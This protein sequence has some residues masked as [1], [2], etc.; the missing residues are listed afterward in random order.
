MCKRAPCIGTPVDIINIIEAK[1]EDFV[2]KNFS[3][4]LLFPLYILGVTNGPTRAIVQNVKDDGSCIFFNNDGLCDI[5]EIKPTEGLW[6]NC[7]KGPN[8][9]EL[10][11]SILVIHEW[12]VDIDNSLRLFNMFM[13]KEEAV[14]CVHKNR[15]LSF[16]FDRLHF[17]S[18]K[19][20][21]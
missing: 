5:H 8:V 3:P 6:T 10:D 1:G 13:P 17:C 18:L 21:S 11:P 4:T 9:L 14:S 7:H 19:K 16:K 15:S 20:E 12:T 2:K